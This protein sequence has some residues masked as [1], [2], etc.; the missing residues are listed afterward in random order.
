MLCPTA[1]TERLEARL[2]H[3]LGAEAALT[4]V[5]TLHAMADLHALHGATGSVLD[6][7][8]YPIGGLVAP[9]GSVRFRHHDP[10]SLAQRLASSRKGLVVVDGWCTH[11]GRAA[12]LAD[13]ATVAARYGS[14]LVVD[15]TQ[16]MGVIGRGATARSPIGPDGSGTLVAAG[17][18]G[19]PAIIAVASTSK[20]LGVPITLVAG[21]RRV[22]EH[23]RSRGPTRTHCSQP[24]AAHIAALGRALDIDDRWGMELRRRLVARID[25]FTDRFVATGFRVGGGGFPVLTVDVPRGVDPHRVERRLAGEGVFAIVVGGHRRPQLTFVVRADHSPSDI[26]RGVRALQRCV[27]PRGAMSARG[28]ARTISVARRV[29]KE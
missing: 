25:H 22:V 23:L 10:E 28:P 14:V 3:R 13:L 20:G 24:S 29:V 26:E 21:P 16:A 8:A 1:G 7:Y 19:H 2:R 18:A 5:S 27:N 6:E 12:P 17:V 15:D 9:P 4:T 11:C